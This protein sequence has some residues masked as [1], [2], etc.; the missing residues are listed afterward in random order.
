[1]LKFA[2]PALLVLL[3][4]A[5]CAEV[6]TYSNKSV[7]QGKKLQ[8]EGRIEEAAGAF[9]NA[10]QQNPT[11]Y[12]AFYYLAQCY[13]QMGREQQAIQCY[14]T[15]LEVFKPVDPLSHA[16]EARAEVETRDALVNAYAR[17]IAHSAARDSE[18][19]ALADRAQV[20]NNALDTYVL[21]RANAE[22]GDADAAVAA[23]ERA[24]Q[25]SNGRDRAILK[26]YGN[27]LVQI[28][29]KEQ[30]AATFRR[31]YVLTPDDPDVSNELRKLGIVPGPSLLP[32]DQ[33]SKPVL[34]KG[35]LP[36]LEINVTDHRSQPS[37][38]AQP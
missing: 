24:V 11:N 28:G 35:P 18:L 15:A 29:Q 34:P 32:P 23:Y 8:A 20:S 25:L 3:A 17:A 7:A 27:Y 19:G 12:E 22:A 31:L 5:G 30:A 37:T 1:M 9:R 36:E 38:P 2:R 21:A 10:T 4:A 33:L 13:E 6:V 14:R 26:S 16:P